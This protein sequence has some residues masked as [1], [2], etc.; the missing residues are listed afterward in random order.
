M[1]KRKTTFE[2]HDN[3]KRKHKSRIFTRAGNSLVIHSHTITTEPEPEDETEDAE[4]STHLNAFDFDNS[5][6]D[7]EPHDSGPVPARPV[8]A[9]S[10]GIKDAPLKNWIKDFR[11]TSLDERM[12]YEG[13]G[14]GHRVGACAGLKCQA[15]GN[16]RCEDCFGR[17]MFCRACCL[18][19]HRDQPLHRIKEWNGDYFKSLTL[20]DI[21]LRVQLGENHAP[22]ASCVFKREVHK[23]FVVLHTNGIHLVN[24]DS[25]GCSGLN[26]PVVSVAQQL[27]RAGWYPAS[28][29]SPQTCATFEVMQS[30][31]LISL[32]GKI[33]HYNYY[34]SLQYRTDNTGTKKLPYRYPAFCLMVRKWRHETMLKRAGRAFVQS[35]KRVEETAQGELAVLCR[36]CPIPSV[37]LPSDWAN[38]PPEFQFLYVLVVCVDACFRFKNR[39]RS[40]DNKDPTLGPGWSYMLD[41]DPYLQHIKKYASEAEIS[42]CAGF[43]AVHLA[44]LKGMKGHRTSGVAGVCCARH[45][46][47][48]PNGIGDL[49]VGERHANID[50]IFLSAIVGFTLMS[51]IV[52]YDIACQYLKHFWERVPRLPVHLHPN[53]KPENLKGKIPKF[54]FDAHIKKDHAQYSFNFTRGVGRINGEGIERLWGWIKQ[55]VG[56]TVEM[57]PGARHDVL[58][59]FFGYGN[60]RKM[61]DIGNFLLKA[62]VAAIPEAIFHRRAFE[63]FDA[64]L[65]KEMPEQVQQWDKDYAEW[66]KEPKAS[67]CI[68]DSADRPLS[69]PQIKLQLA[70]EEAAKSGLETSAAQ[71]PS[72]FIFM[73]LEV[74]DMQRKLRSD[75]KQH[76]DP[77]TLQKSQFQSRRVALRKRILQVRE[78]QAIY[79]PG[80]RTVLPDPT[81]LDD[82][83]HARAE[84]I[85]LYFPSDLNTGTIRDRACINGIPDVE[86]RA[87]QA[88]AYDNLHDLRRHLLTRTFLNKWRVK[89]VSGQR[90]STRARSLQHTID[91]KVH[92]AKIRYRR[93]RSALFALRGSGHWESILKELKDDDVRGL[94]E[95]L[96]TEREKAER[97]RRIATGKPTDQDTLEGVPVEGTLGDGKRTLSWIWILY[98]G[99]D[100]SPEM[101]EALRIEWAKC[102]AR[103]ARWHEELML[104]K[105]E[106]RRVLQFSEWKWLWW[107]DRIAMR[108]DDDPTLME[109]LRAYALEHADDELAIKESLSLKWADIRKR[110]EVVL[111][112]LALPIYSITRF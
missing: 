29:I 21:G 80:L 68:F 6:N 91:M 92:D 99:E 72:T 84:D 22:G 52:S 112:D 42:T 59:D 69:M 100:N 4:S 90:T 76:P 102:R 95:R 87:R 79:M 34:K 55:A 70:N 104:L 62:M 98:S 50:Y 74:E 63:E 88:L 33:S 81:V 15:E 96:M 77:T 51:I 40:N 78:L 8:S 41:H 9:E 27:M 46:T 26:G 89:N 60:F 49:Q 28:H 31:H 20:R 30:F 107:R 10:V 71:T 12:R 53:V 3:S 67:P 43:A 82:A 23:D 25:C 48:R 64:H 36:A 83:P 32:Q 2:L 94:N 39:M 57:G 101:I 54:H 17:Q 105:E 37:N 56:Q 18:K 65:R 97:E 5:N 75:M 111:T 103:A 14:G 45:D 38:A 93:S 61:T 66:D 106:M 7:N 35:P 110:V 13:R 86:A 109:G 73:A 1:G 58:D 16:V 85:R 108:S 19:H 24:V 11:T 44:N 47:F